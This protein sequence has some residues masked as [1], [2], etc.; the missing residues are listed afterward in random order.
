MIV[1]RNLRLKK[2]GYHDAVENLFSSSPLW[3]DAE[4]RT[5]IYKCNSFF[6]NNVSHVR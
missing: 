5:S 6:Y 3:I 1:D 4:L 2:L